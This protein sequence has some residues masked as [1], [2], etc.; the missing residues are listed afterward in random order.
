LILKPEGVVNGCGFSSTVLI[1]NK[2]DVW[3]EREVVD[4]QPDEL[5]IARQYV[6]KSWAGCA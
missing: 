5:I 2:N 1:E 6:R 3:I 4:T